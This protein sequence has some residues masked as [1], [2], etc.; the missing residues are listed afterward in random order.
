MTARELPTKDESA[1]ERV[2]EL[3]RVKLYEESEAGRRERR[4]R[5]EAHDTARLARMA[6]R[7][8]R[9]P[10][11]GKVKGYG[12]TC[13]GDVCRHRWLLLPVDGDE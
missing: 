2:E 13:G 6:E 10:Y 7:S 3:P 4:E 12:V 11:C 1:A 5:V 9:C 8:G